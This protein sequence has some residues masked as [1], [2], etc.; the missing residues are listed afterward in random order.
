MPADRLHPA[1]HAALWLAGALVLLLGLVLAVGGDLSADGSSFAVCTGLGLIVSGAFI[2]AKHLA[3]TWNALR[4]LRLAVLRVPRQLAAR[5]GTAFTRFCSRLAR[6]EGGSHGRPNRPP[7]PTNPT[8]RAALYDRQTSPH[9]SDFYAARIV[10]PASLEGIGWDILLALHS[11]RHPCLG[12]APLASIISVCP[13]VANRWL[14]LLEHR[15]LITGMRHP[16]SGE[17]LAVLTDKGRALL[18]RYLSATCE[19]QVGAHP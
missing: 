4:V 19:L 6:N 12:I 14:G 11:D 16:S 10:P 9:A 15:E 3:G 7:E 8:P 2:S 18:D 5:I 13:A 1:L 17:L